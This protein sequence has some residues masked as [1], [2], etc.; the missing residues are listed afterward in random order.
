MKLLVCAVC[1][2]MFPLG[3]INNA[4]SQ[5]QLGNIAAPSWEKIQQNLIPNKQDVSK[6]IKWI[7]S[8]I[9]LDYDPTIFSQQC[10]E[11]LDDL[12]KLVWVNASS[13]NQTQFN[14]KWEGVFDLSK[15]RFDHCFESG[16]CGWE[17]FKIDCVE[18]LGSLGDGDWFQLS[19]SG[20]CYE[21]K[22]SEKLKRIIRLIPNR[23]TFSIDYIINPEI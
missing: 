16:N 23:E 9:T 13:D 8:S 4:Y 19:I 11:F 17:S 10:Q 20:S 3:G 15:A 22:Y 7:E 5:N 1:I 21:N 18:Y 14:K 6:S 12:N 2:L